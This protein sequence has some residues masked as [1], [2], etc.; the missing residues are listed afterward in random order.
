MFVKDGLKNRIYIIITVI[1]NKKDS[2]VQYMHAS[3]CTF[4]FQ[5]IKILYKNIFKIYIM[6]FN[7]RG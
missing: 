2:P 6:C 3:N 7:F 4:H 5:Y 1:Y